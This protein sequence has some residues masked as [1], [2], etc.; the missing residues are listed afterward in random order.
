MRLGT[1]LL[2]L[3]LWAAGHWTWAPH[4]P[5]IESAGSTMEPF[6]PGLRA[7]FIVTEFAAAVFAM[8]K[9]V[10][11]PRARL[12]SVM[13]KSFFALVTKRALVLAPHALPTMLVVSEAL[14]AKFT[15]PLMVMLAA[16]APAVPGEA[17]ATKLAEAVVMVA[18][19]LSAAFVS[20]TFS[21]AP[22]IPMVPAPSVTGEAFAAK[23]AEAVMVV[24][25]ATLAAA[26]FASRAFSFATAIPMMA[27]LSAA[28]EAF[29]TKLAEALMMAVFAPHSA[30]PFRAATGEAFATETF[31]ELVVM[32]FSLHPRTT[33]RTVL[34]KAASLFPAERRTTTFAPALRESLPAKF[35]E[36]M[37]MMLTRHA[38]LRTTALR[39]RVLRPRSRRLLAARSSARRG[40][41]RESLRWL[42][43]LRTLP[44][45][46]LSEPLSGLHTEGRTEMLLS[47]GARAAALHSL[48]ARRISRGARLRPAHPLH[49]AG[50]Q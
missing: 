12:G 38:T 15:A 39:S 46:A 36:S 31:S 48:R 45:S 33:L 41:L 23:F 20:E 18:F 27:L 44:W 49:G 7:A 29:A 10:L 40:V 34:F 14:A 17:F 4:L 24:A 13:G 19:A 1:G 3:R 21:F 8:R 32:P 22:A 47:V 11:T 26:A 42:A 43:R 9:A 35:A 2:S 50:R 16:F 6:L 5:V 25:F 37:M 30:L 28:G